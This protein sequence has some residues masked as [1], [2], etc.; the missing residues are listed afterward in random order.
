MVAVSSLGPPRG[1]V[2]CP[3]IFPPAL[4][5]QG[6]VANSLG[7]TG[8][9]LPGSCLGVSVRPSGSG[10]LT[11]P[12]EQGPM[13]MAESPPGLFKAQLSAGGNLGLF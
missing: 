3:A 8:G 9:R 6:T 10:G 1:P 11:C 12:Q 4:W 13:V 2:S 7:S 5:G